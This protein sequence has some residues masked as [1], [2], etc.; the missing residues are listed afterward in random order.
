M[1]LG[2][3]W[4]CILQSKWT[5]LVP[6][7]TGTFVFAVLPFLEVLRRSFWDEKKNFFSVVNYRNLWEN[8]AF[9]LAVK[10]TVKFVG[11]CIPLLLF[12]SLVFALGLF[13]SK[14]MKFLKSAFLLPL[15]VP[16]AVVVFVWKLI[17]FKE[18]LLNMFLG[19]FSLKPVDWLGGE[20]AFFVLVISYVWKN[21]GYTIVLW[22]AAMAAIPKEMLEAAEVD[23][24][25][26]IQRL[27][28]MVLPSLKPAFY[29]ITIVSFLNSFKVFREAYLVAGSYPPKSMYLLQHLF[30][31]WFINLELGK[32]SAGGV[33]MALLFV[34]VTMLLQHIWDK[35]E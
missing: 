18:G 3:K 21:M 10:N 32:I 30:N 35:S 24:S 29:T 7:L 25:N 14:W 16:T 1:K 19:L 34:L 33:M 17:F 22:L 23:G 28:Y 31:N 4:N 9:C 26:G 5:F 15:A 8:E 12:L 11:V 20:G 27:Y 2:R 13:H 6:S